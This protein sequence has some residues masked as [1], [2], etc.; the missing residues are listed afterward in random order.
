MFTRR[1]K[2]PWLLI[3]PSRLLWFVL[4]GA[5]DDSWQ[6][7]SHLVNRNF[8]PAIITPLHLPRWSTSRQATVSKRKPVKARRCSSILCEFFFFE[9]NDRALVG[10]VNASARCNLTFF[11]VPTW[12][13]GRRRRVVCSNG[14][15]NSSSAVFFPGTCYCYTAQRSFVDTWTVCVCRSARTLPVIDQKTADQRAGVSLI[16]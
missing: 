8:F 6:L 5:H 12:S 1:S 15:N 2:K 11:F 13:C 10:D 7:D 16:P 14:S 3:L 4:S 9:R